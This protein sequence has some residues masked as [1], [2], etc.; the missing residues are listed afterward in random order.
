M[1][2]ILKAKESYFLMPYKAGYSVFKIKEGTETRYDIS[3]EHTCTCEG[4]KRGECRHVKMLHGDFYYKN[5]KK[6]PYKLG[7]GLGFMVAR[8]LMKG[9]NASR[10]VP[11]GELKQEQHIL[12]RID[13]LAAYK[14]MCMPDGSVIYGFQRIGDT[15]ITTRTICYNDLSFDVARDRVKKGEI[16]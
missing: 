16:K 13:I 11:V 14:N 4:F 2:R 5:G 3:E 12:R 8:D 6:E 7:F 1:A 10:W 9:T 15:G